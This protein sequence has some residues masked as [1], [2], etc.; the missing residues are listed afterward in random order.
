MRNLRG[1]TAF[2]ALLLAAAVSCPAFALPG[3]ASAVIAHC[4][5]P[6]A[7]NRDTSPVTGHLQRDLYY[8]DTILH[9]EPMEG[10]WSFTTAWSG[11]LPVSRA[12]MEHK[13][14]CFRD[15]MNE[16]ASFPQRAEDPTIAQQTVQSPVISS[17]GFGVP[18][19]WVVLALVVVLIILVALPTARRR[20]QRAPLLEQRPYRK[21]DLSE[22]GFH[23]RSRDSS[24]IDP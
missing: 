4:G 3:E 5:Q 9:F 22:S 21:P 13:M 16:A 12:G 1:F 14:P 6:T 19:L 18:F 23:S 11:H 20:A 8:G 10:G 2:S 7:E 17:N 24:R 15:A